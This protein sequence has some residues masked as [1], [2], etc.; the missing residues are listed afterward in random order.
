MD[1]R[2]QDALLLGAVFFHDQLYAEEPF[3]DT[4]LCSWRNTPYPL[5]IFAF[6]FLMLLFQMPFFF[7]HLLSF[8]LLVISL[9]DD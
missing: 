3:P 2:F 5:T 7:Y 6:C 9:S 4:E 1:F 8:L